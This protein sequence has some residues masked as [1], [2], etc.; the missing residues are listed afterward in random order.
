MNLNRLKVLSP[1]ALFALLFIITYVVPFFPKSFYINAYNILFTAIILVSVYVVEKPRKFN[2][3]TAFIVIIIKWSILLYSN[4]WR[5]I[6]N[7]LPLIFFTYI[8]LSLLVQIAR[9]KT[10]KKHVIIDCINGYFLSALV[11]ALLIG[12]TAYFSPGSFNFAN[13]EEMVIQG[14]N[15]YIYHSLVVFSTTGFGD[16][17]PMTPVAKSVSTFISVAGQ[18]YVAIIISLLIG[19][20]SSKISQPREPGQ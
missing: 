20:H 2:L 19:H 11:C 14:M 15:E 6:S 5:N 3:V 16:I 8:V 17:I 1:L 10:R 9:S 7:I 12:L 13:K 4:E 18:L